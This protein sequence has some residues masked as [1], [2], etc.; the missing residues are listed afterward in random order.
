MTRYQVIEAAALRYQQPLLIRLTI[1]APELYRY[2]ISYCADTTGHIQNLGS[3][4]AIAEPIIS[5]DF[6][7]PE[8]LRVCVIACVLLDHC[9]IKSSAC[10]RIDTFI[11]V[12]VDDGVHLSRFW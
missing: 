6:S 2:A 10:P 5:R 4:V 11:A 3:V 9:T 12:P 1:V 8:L 7:E